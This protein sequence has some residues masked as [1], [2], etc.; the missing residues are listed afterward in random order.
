MIG[1][2]LVINTSGTHGGGEPL[3]GRVKSVIRTSSTE[4]RRLSTPRARCVADCARKR[5]SDPR[6]RPI[7]VYA[8]RVFKGKSGIVNGVST[9]WRC[10]KVHVCRALLVSLHRPSLWCNQGRQRGPRV[11]GIDNGVEDIAVLV[12]AKDN[13]W[14][15]S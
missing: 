15:V 8:L 1:A 9:F 4:R 6:M 3:L 10:Q 12:D 7:I 11:R 13:T 14:A 5:R 2:M